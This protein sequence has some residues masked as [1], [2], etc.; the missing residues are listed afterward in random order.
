MGRNIR[1]VQTFIRFVQGFGVVSG[2]INVECAD[3]FASKP[4]PTLVLLWAIDLEYTNA[5]MWERACSRRRRFRQH[6]K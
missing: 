6:Q 5:L 2:D 4:A 1:G 3:L